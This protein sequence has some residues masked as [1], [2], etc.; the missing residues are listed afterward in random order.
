MVIEAIQ[1]VAYR[2]V[3][4]ARLG[5]LGG[6]MK[7]TAA[8]IG[9]SVVALGLAAVAP[10]PPASATS[11]PCAAPVVSGTTATVT[12]NYTGDV[13]TWT[14][15]STVTQATFRVSGASGG[16]NGSSGGLGGLTTATISVVP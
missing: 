10:G 11:T 16:S 4:R 7:R 8:L 12:C 2:L 9:A 15:P 1:V 13:Q 3:P 14:V 6:T 5:T